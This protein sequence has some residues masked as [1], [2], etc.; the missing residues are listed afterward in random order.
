MRRTLIQPLNVHPTRGYAHAVQV[1][2]V[3]Y[4]SGQV[5]RDPHDDIVDPSDPEAQV[6]Q[7]FA[8]LLGVIVAAGGD[9]SSLVK[10][11]TYL[12][13]QAHF[14]T[15]RKVRSEVLKEPYPASTLV[16]VDSLSYPEYLVEI[17]AIAAIDGPSG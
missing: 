3:L 14:D 4:I 5:P 11:T 8:N 16:I 6:R 15:W 17:E 9:A 7:V 10:V 12:T 2:D 1:G 13:D